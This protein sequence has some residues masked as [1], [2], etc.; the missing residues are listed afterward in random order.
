MTVEG[1]PFLRAQHLLNRPFPH[2]RETLIEANGTIPTIIHQSWKEDQLPHK[3]LQWSN[4][5]RIRHPEWQWVGEVIA[6]RIGVGGPLI[7]ATRT[8]VLWTDADNDQLVER[9]WPM[10][11]QTYQGLRG[12]IYRADFVRNLYMYTYG[13]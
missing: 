4:S 13:G 1:A 8:Q 7:E 12:N 10:L 3:F 2:T 9:H 6:R 11:N 5:W